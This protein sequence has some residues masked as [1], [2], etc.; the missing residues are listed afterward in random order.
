M[1]PREKMTRAKFQVY[2][3]LF[4]A[5]IECDETYSE[6]LEKVK[7]IYDACAQ[8]YLN[9]E[10]DSDNVPAGKTRLERL[11]L[12]NQVL[13]ATAGRLYNDIHRKDAAKNFAQGESHCPRDLQD[14]A[15]SQDILAT[16][17]IHSMPVMPAAASRPFSAMRITSSGVRMDTW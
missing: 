2:S 15:D 4:D 7:T 1:V 5:V 8:P 6:V 17:R 3:E 16:E 12:E 14:D 11:M 13:K 10:F 9:P